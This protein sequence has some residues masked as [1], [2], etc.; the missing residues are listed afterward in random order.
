MS[1]QEPILSLQ[2]AKDT[3]A[4]KPYPRVTEASIKEKIADVHYLTHNSLTVCIIEMQNGFMVNGQSAPAHDGNYDAEVGKRYAYDNAFKQL[5]VL[6]GYLLRQQLHERSND[7]AMR[8]Q[9]EAQT[10]QAN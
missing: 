4:N 5:W 3:V 8:K 1:N 9:E 7:D 6:E 2:E 10:R